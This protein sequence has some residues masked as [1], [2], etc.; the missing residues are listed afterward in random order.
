[1]SLRTLPLCLASA[2]AAA[3]LAP[4]PAH[5]GCTDL[6]GLCL[7]PIKGGK[8]EPDAS[9]SGKQ[10]KAKRKGAPG[11]LSVTIEDGRGSVF[12]DGRLAGTAPVANLTL[13]PGKHDLQVRDGQKILA[14]GVLTIPKGASVRV[15]VRH[16]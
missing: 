2:L 16:P 14:E 13:G 15:V 5:A 8:W 10:L 7:E 3:V 4:S 6:S 1:M 9:L 12:V 11:K